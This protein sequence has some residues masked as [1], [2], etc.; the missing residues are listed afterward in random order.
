M[1]ISR[2]AMLNPAPPFFIGIGVKYEIRIL[3]CVQQTLKVYCN[4]DAMVC[5]T[6]RLGKSVAFEMTSTCSMQYC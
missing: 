6:T 4:L 1:E 2:M 5:C 3:G